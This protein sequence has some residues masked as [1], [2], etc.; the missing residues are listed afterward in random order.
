MHKGD[1]QIGLCGD[2]WGTGTHKT[3]IQDRGERT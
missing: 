1:R 3:H 2:F